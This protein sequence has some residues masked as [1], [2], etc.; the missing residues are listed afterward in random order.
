MRSWV[1]GRG[2]DTFSISSAIAFASYT[3]T[4]MGNTVSPPT[5]FNITIGIF[6][7]GSSIRPRTVIST[8]IGTSLYHQFTGEAVGETAGNV[9]RHIASE[10]QDCA[11]GSKVQSF[12]M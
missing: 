5:S 8:S 2:V 6:E 3:P 9:H 4:Q 11:I 12:V 7:T 1:I 10:L